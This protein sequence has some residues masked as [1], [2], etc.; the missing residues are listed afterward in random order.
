MFLHVELKGQSITP[1]KSSQLITDIKAQP[2]LAQLQPPVSVAAGRP[3]NH[4]NRFSQRWKNNINHI[5][6]HIIYIYM[7]IYIHISVYYHLTY[8]RSHSPKDVWVAKHDIVKTVR[9]CVSPHTK[10][11]IWSPRIPCELHK[12][13]PQ[14][15]LPAGQT[16]NAPPVPGSGRWAR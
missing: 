4:P 9:I 10:Q 13:S 5:Y 14:K 8:S 6:N 16:W 3:A 2:H 11:A 7:Y 15:A 1:Q 12:I